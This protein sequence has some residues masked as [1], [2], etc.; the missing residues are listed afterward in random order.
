M[1]RSLGADSDREKRFSVY[2]MCVIMR[3]RSRNDERAD[4]DTDC[5]YK[6]SGRI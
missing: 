1:T 4:K 5:S 3:E 2:D 6:R